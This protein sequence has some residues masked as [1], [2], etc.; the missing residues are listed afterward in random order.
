MNK[1]YIV[2][3][4]FRRAPVGNGLVPTTNVSGAEKYGELVTLLD[5]YA[6]T[7]PNSSSIAKL[8][9]RLKDCT[10]DDFIL[11]IGTP[12]LIGIACAIVQ[13]NTGGLNLL[14]WNKDD[15]KYYPVYFS[16]QPPKGELDGNTIRK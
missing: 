4:G 12:Y 5:Q 13:E 10:G 9:T 1:V 2:Q 7:A 6:D 11:P 16:I 15:R 14:R 3:M 8:V